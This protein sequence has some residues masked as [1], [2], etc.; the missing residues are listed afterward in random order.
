[1]RF[2]FLRC[3]R[4]DENVG[5]RRGREPDIVGLC[6]HISQLPDQLIDLGRILFIRTGIDGRIVSFIV[7]HQHRH[8]NSM[9]QWICVQI[10]SVW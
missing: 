10:L 7:N 9:G 4:I 6:E 3:F 5:K 1:M 2:H 8:I